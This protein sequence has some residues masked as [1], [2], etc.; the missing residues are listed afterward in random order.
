MPQYT[1]DAF[2][3][4]YED[5]PCPD[6]DAKHRGKQRITSVEAQVVRRQTTSGRGA[7][8][9]P[10]VGSMKDYLHGVP[11]LLQISLDNGHLVGLSLGGVDEKYNIAPM[12]GWFNEVRYRAV[13]RA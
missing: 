12:V 13:E 2:R 8:P 9:D 4:V 3:C 10:L 1:K 11:A 5:I 7:A 6:S